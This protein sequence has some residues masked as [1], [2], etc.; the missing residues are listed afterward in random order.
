MLSLYN[1]L[2]KQKQLFKPA[3]PPHVNMYVCGPTVYDDAHLGHA[4]CYIAWDVLARVLA[5]LGYE[6][7]YARNITDVDDKIIKRASEQGVPFAQWAERYTQRFHEDMAA[8]NVAPPTDEPKAT[9]HIEGIIDGCNALIDNGHA[10]ATERGNVY[11]RTASKADYGKLSRKPLEDLK[12]GARVVGEDDKE[13]PLDFALWKAASADDGNTWPSPWGAA[14]CQQGRPGWH[15]ECSAMN[16]ALFDS[17][18]DI[19]AGGADLTFPHHE[20]EIA[21]SEA[22]SGHQPFSIY[23]LHN[24]FV[25]VD[26]DKMSKSLANFATVRDLLAHYPANGLRHFLLTHHYRMPVD[27]TPYGLQAS[28]NRVGKIHKSLKRGSDALNL[29]EVVIEHLDPLAHNHPAMAAFTE[30]LCDDLNTPRALAELDAALTRL[31]KTLDTDGDNPAMVREAFMPAYS[32]WHTLGFAINAIYDVTPLPTAL[33]DSLNTLLASE[34]FEQATTPEDAIDRVLA[35]R[36]QAK[37][38]KNWPMADKLRDALNDLGISIKDSKQGAEWSYQP[39]PST[40][41]AA[42]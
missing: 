22:W 16:H 18:L 41:A 40:A 24:G 36:Q 8:L 30:A 12:S 9:D 38:D 28:T 17:K 2:A 23:W 6:V 11:F 7:R 35:A 37:A 15:M 42:K 32:M 31:N 4:R 20:N 3:V 34:G 26:G 5:F 29:A 39:V 21:Q 19:H 25:T 1:T 10:Y 13:S 27:F 33:M 14:G